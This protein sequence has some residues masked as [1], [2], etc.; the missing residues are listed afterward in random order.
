MYIF[1][2]VPHSM[3]DLSFLIKNWTLAPCIE[4]AKFLTTGLPEK[5][6]ELNIFYINPFSDPFWVETLLEYS[7]SFHLLK[8]FL[9]EYVPP[10]KKKSH[11]SLE[12]PFGSCSSMEPSQVFPSPE[13]KVLFSQ[14]F[15]NES[16]TCPMT[17]SN[18]RL[19]VS[20]IPISCFQHH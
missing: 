16:H 5:S 14:W 1:L 8:I 15:G 2:T 20:M 11:P 17:F 19:M 3:W 13:L 4:S 7:G 10:P 12:A 18:N 9:L 6:L